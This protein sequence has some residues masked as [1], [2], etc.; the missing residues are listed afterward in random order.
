MSKE[1]MDTVWHEKYRARKLEDLIIPNRLFG[2]FEK[3]LANPM[4]FPNIMLHSAGAGLMKTTT[5]QVLANEMVSRYKTKSKQINSSKDGNKETIE[6]EIVEWGS[7]N[8]FSKAPKIVI[9]D[10]TD[11]CNAKTFLDPLLGTTE[12]LHKSVRFI[13]TSNSLHNFSEYS[14]SRIE[15]LDFSIQNE[16]EARELKLKMYARLVHICEAEKLKYDPNTLKALIKTFFPDMRKLMSRMYSCYLRHGEIVG[17]DFSN[18]RTFDKYARIQ[19]LIL[20]G[21]FIGTRALYNTMP[22]ENDIFTALMSDFI[23]KVQDPFRQMK[24]VCAIRNHM[25]PHNSVIDKEINIASMF[26]EIIL[27]LRAQ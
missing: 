25:I 17:T 10:E 23:G 6:K 14:E 1:L 3:C 12:E 2:F 22:P 24:I 13:M 9:L 18:T 11:K 4:Q 27:I 21:D 15:V 19:E 20:A 16:E 8:G 7:Y 26:A 5:A